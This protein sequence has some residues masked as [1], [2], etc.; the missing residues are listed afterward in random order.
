MTWKETNPMDQKTRLIGDWLDNEY[1]ITELSENF[2]VS[3]KTIYK[4]IDRYKHGNVSDLEEKSRAPHTHPNA[5]APEIVTQLISTKLKHPC[6]GPKKISAWL[7]KKDTETNW[8]VPSTT[9]S[10]LKKEGLV[11]K[12][13][14]THHTPPYTEPFRD[15][16]RPNDV[17]SMDYKGHFRMLDSKYCYPFT[18]TDNFSRYLLECRG[19][20]H[21][22]YEETQPWLERAFHEYGLPL[23]MRNDNG[24]PFA[25]VG[26]G[27]ISKLSVWL[28]KLWIR[29]ERIEPGHPEQNGRHERM[30][31]TLKEETAN[32]PKANLECQQ[33][34]FDHFRV[35][36]DTERPHEALGQK[37]PASIYT[38]SRRIFPE[39]L[40]DVE[41]GSQYMVRQ[42]RSN[43]EIKWK[44]KLVF[45]SEALVGEPVGLRQISDSEWDIRFSFHPLGILD[46]RT[47]KVMKNTKDKI[48]V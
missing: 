34:A 33:K 47:G 48:K 23:A 11:K 25:S 40:A 20:L 22:T 30:H 5:T 4:W 7:R 38:P 14:Y 36:F 24:V 29:P 6:W 31:R 28:I 8:P 41:Y 3:R 42:V 46:E 2:G 19:L 26:L 1:T 21:P 18:L 12:R 32:P 45:V 27:G 10:I 13:H 44:G 15:C 43:G 16:E 37:V 39:K 9:G 17:W 35:E